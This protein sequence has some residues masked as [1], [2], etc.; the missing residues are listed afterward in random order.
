MKF[1]IQV[2]NSPH[3]T[4]LYG[5]VRL[6]IGGKNNRVTS[7]VKMPSKRLATFHTPV[8]KV[9]KSV[10]WYATPTFVL[11][12]GMIAVHKVAVIYG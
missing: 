1:E 3:L 9:R 2:F 8:L 6:N 7:V 12:I 11:A 5:G 4:K 10:S